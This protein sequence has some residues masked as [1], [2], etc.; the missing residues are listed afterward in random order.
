MENSEI[1]TKAISYI[2]KSYRKKD[3][4]IDNIAANAGF[5]TDYFNR[6]FCAHTGF[7]AMEYLRFTRIKNAAQQIRFTEKSILDIALDCGYENHE[8]FSRA[9]RKQYGMSPTE[10]R[11]KYEKTEATFGEFHNETVGARLTYEFKNFKIADK[12]E[13]IDYM[14]EHDALRYGYIAACCYQNGGVALYSGENFKDGFVWFTEWGERFEGDIICDNWEKIAEYVTTFSDDRFDLMIFT[15]ADDDTIKQNLEK[16]GVSVREIKR[17]FTNVY[18]GEPYELTVPHGITMRELNY[19]DYDILKKHFTEIC[20]KPQARINWLKREL[21]QRDVLGNT[22]SSTFIFG[23]FKDNHLIGYS[24]GCLLRVH[25]FIVN[26][27]VASWVS[28]EFVNEEIYQYAFKFITNAALAK[29]ALPIDDVQTEVVEDQYRCG[30]F[31]STDFGYKTV[32]CPCC[33]KIKS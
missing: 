21:Y 17:H 33:I 13:V 6:I 28:E 31:N 26:N 7:N 32:T 23:I 30:K 27:C 10:Y 5:C 9:F 15:L 8:S 22:E 1:I 16:Y 24:E 18:T 12:D 29:D 3:I 20:R 2:N 25:G 14:L 4:N 19:C 11:K